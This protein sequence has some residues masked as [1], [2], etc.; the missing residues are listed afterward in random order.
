MRFR[1]AVLGVLLIPAAAHAQYKIELTPQIGWQYG[2]TQ[3]YSAYPGYSS[4]DFHANANLNYGGTLSIY[5]RPGYAAEI[6]YSYQGTDL[7]L[8]P[9][10]QSDVNLGNM[11][12]QY[13]LLQGMR[14]VPLQSGTMELIALGGFGTA[15]FSSEGYDSRWLTAFAAGGGLRKKMNERS[16]I[17]LQARLLV[18]I[19]WSSTGFYFGSGGSGISVS[20]GS[21]I[22][23]GDVS[24]GVSVALGS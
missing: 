21:S 16:A 18:P 7:L 10:N 20:G 23:Q 11:A 1:L 2:G 6:T 9:N 22:I 8:R 17:R 4:G 3:E 19:Q 14:V 13:I 12:S 24:L 5:M 15:V